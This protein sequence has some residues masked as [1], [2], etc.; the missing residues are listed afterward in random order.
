M[1]KNLLIVLLVLFTGS[2]TLP[3]LAAAKSENS[4]P[5]ISAIKID[6]KNSNS[7]TVKMSDE[8]INCLV[9]RLNEIRDMD[10]KQLSK[11]DKRALKQ[12]VKDIKD[13]LKQQDYVLYISLTALLIILLLIILL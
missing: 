10:K 7:A 2:T 11:A 1:K 5:K 12:E 3:A 13:T 4:K 9:T 8:E 6:T